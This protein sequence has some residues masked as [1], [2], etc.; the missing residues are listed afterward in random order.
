[1]LTQM[2]LGNASAD[3]GAPAKVITRSLCEHGNRVTAKS[4]CVVL[5]GSSGYLWLAAATECCSALSA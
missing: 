1:M 4:R 2:R 5:L 3:K